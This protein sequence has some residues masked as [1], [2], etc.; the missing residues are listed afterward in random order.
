MKIET[1]RQFILN[2]TEAQALHDLI[3]ELSLNEHRRLLANPSLKKSLYNGPIEDAHVLLSEM[4]ASL[5]KE[6][7]TYI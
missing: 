2:E 4:Y 7:T 3:A 1:T 6:F 5:H